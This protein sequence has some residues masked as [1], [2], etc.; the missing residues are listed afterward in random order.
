MSEL[1]F[2]HIHDGKELKMFLRKLTKLLIHSYTLVFLDKKF[3][4]IG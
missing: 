4:N 1:F 3:F 2:A